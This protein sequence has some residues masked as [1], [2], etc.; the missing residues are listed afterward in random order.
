MGKFGLS[1]SLNR[2]LGITCAKQK[3][4]RTT[5]MSVTK[6]GR[7]RKVGKLVTGGGCLVPTLVVV[8]LLASA[9]DV[10]KMTGRLTVAPAHLGG[11][12]R[13]SPLPAPRLAI[14]GCARIAAYQPKFSL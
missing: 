6:A 9:F 4:A 3:I 2:A 5:G 13:Y 8:G 12:V 11:V 14:D 10:E 1:F 7:Q